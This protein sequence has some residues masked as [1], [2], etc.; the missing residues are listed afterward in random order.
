MKA[1]VT[2]LNDKLEKSATELSEKTSALVEKTNALAMLNAGVNKPSAAKPPMTK[3]Q[4]RQKLATMPLSQR[5][6]FYRQNK[7][8]IDG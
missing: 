6:E 1:E 3:S 2:S 8:L 4:A 5:A 7:D